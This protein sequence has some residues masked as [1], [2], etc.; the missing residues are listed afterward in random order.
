MLP[1]SGLEEGG[2][3]P[4]SVLCQSC[5]TKGGEVGKGTSRFP[6]LTQAR[7]GN[8]DVGM[9]STW[10][11]GA[12]EVA[13]G[14][15]GAAVPSPDPAIKVAKCVCQVMVP[16]QEIKPSPCRMLSWHHPATG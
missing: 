10:C 4:A 6:A 16:R 9:G 15:S 12:E 3:S 5:V 7:L 13:Q 8:G 14:L 1:G 2:C 11:V